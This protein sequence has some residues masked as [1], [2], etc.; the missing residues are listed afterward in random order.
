M[1]LD[2]HVHTV[3][4][5]GALPPAEVVEAARA[6]GLDVISVT[7][8]DTTASVAEA[9]EVG[10]RVG[11]EVIPGSELSSTRDGR[12]LHILGYF[13]DPTS[14]RLQAHHL[15]ARERREARMEGM[16]ERLGEA[17]TPVTMEGVR[18]A[19]GPGHS[20]L[21]RPHLAEALVEAGHVDSV[22][23]AFDRF[24]GDEHPAFIP[25]ALQDP[26]EAIRVIRESGGVAVWAHPPAD[27]IDAL[28]PELVEAGLA[29]LE[30]FR[31][32]TSA[33]FLG[34]L[35]GLARAHGLVLTG[36]SDW[37]DPDRHPPLGEFW[38][39]A[40]EVAAFL[41]IGGL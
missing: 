34:H 7:D 18:E 38:V 6:G 16:V 11:V 19:A 39:D 20:V 10:R 2:L 28:L 25:T 27:R 41:E 17:G 23:E 14:P 12:E 29:G 15:R 40:R 8:H 3:A 4:S 33:G 24:I 37:H 22:G 30:A 5:D 26:V 35:R 32:R 9:R 21:A 31:P 13:I 1:R 36:G